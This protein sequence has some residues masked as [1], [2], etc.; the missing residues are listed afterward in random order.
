M[1]KNQLLSKNVVDI[2][3]KK[4]MAV[5]E[6]ISSMENIGGFSGQHMVD[7]IKILDKIFYR[8]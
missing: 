6:L 4:N 7:G 1:N 2:K 8:T 3:L 5:S